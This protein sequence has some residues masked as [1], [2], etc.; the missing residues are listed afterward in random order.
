MLFIKLMRWLRGYVCFSASD[1]FPERFLNLCNQTGI[2]MWQVSWQGC[3]MHGITDRH[4]FAAMQQCAAPAGI[5]LKATG[6]RGLPFAVHAYRKR[7]GLLAGVAVCMITLAVLSSMVW[8]IEVQGN[9]TIATEE[10]LQVLQEQGLRLGVRRNSLDPRAMAETAQQ[11]L[12]GVGWLTVNLRGSSAVIELREEHSVQPWL[13]TDQPQ[14]IIAAKAGQIRIFELYQGAAE[15][16]LGDAV[17]A[18]A[19]LANGRILNLDETFRYVA[20]DAYV[21]ART[22]VA[23]HGEAARSSQ[24]H[25]LAPGRT[26]YRLQLLNFT[27][28]FGRQGDDT[29]IDTTFHLQLAGRIMPLAL[30]RH[31]EITAQPQQRILTDRQLQLAAAAEFFNRAYTHTRAAQMLEQTITVDLTQDYARVVLHG[32]AYENIGFAVAIAGDVQT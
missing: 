14:H 8:T 11:A 5:A 31:S 24:V 25:R 13:T 23:G 16:M 22:V 9:E 10:I 30:H 29:T 3:N 18:G 6:K 4:G 26:R 20:A 7:T 28:P 15:I 19:L 1:G 17:Y 2:A 32:A 21:V 12:P 27:I